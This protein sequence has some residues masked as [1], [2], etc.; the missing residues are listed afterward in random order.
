MKIELEISK[1]QFN[2]INDAL[3]L[4]C[5]LLLGQFDKLDYLFEYMPGYLE[6]DR[7]KAEGLLSE[8]KKIY[9]PELVG[10]S[11]YGI[12]NEKANDGANIAYELYKTM[13]FKNH[14]LSDNE[15]FNTVYDSPPLEVSKEEMP[16][17]EIKIVSN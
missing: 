4:Y 2:V 13:T 10:N 12:G 5:R 9:F 11:S 3:E 6:K 7:K 16:I 8:L 15:D 14:M 1:K 17:I